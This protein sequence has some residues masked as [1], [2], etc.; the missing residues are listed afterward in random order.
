LCDPAQYAKCKF[1]GVQSR[2]KGTSLVEK[3]LVAYRLLG[4]ITPL[5]IFLASCYMG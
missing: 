3:T 2:D 4:Y 5:C 1:M